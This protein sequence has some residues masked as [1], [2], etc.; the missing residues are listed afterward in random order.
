MHFPENFFW[1]AAISAYQTE[2][3]ITND[4]T[5][6]Y[7][8]GKAVD[9]YNRYDEDFDLAKKLGLNAFRFSIEWARIEPE[10]GRFSDLAIEH[11]KKYISALKQRGP[12]PWLTLWHFTF[13]IWVAKM[14]G[15]ANPDILPYFERF[16]K[17]VAENFGES[18]HFW[19]TINEPTVYANNSYL[20]GRWPPQKIAS[21]AYFKVLKN[22]ARAH[23]LA[24]KIIKSINPDAQVGIAENNTSKR[25]FSR[26]ASTQ[27][28]IGVN[29]YG[30]PQKL[31]PLLQW[32][33]DVYKKP[34]YIT[35]NG[36]DDSLDQKRQKLLA[37][38][39]ENMAKAVQTGIDLRGYF[40]WSLIDNFEWHRGFKP[41]YGL[42]EIDY[43][44]N[45]ARKPRQSYFDYQKIIL[46]PKF[47][48]PI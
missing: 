43:D 16:V 28:F 40:H 29:Y 7:D 9:H 36:I 47:Y 45:L 48:I 11:Y 13:P 26:V 31:I 39:T 24:Y 5:A 22:L 33:N 37:E 21:L 38:M 30:R 10:E 34:I 1:G 35:E 23:G 18:V 19:I 6:S 2:G 8:V 44:N 32:L 20:V 41:R 42:V 27:D 12:E 14:G 15:W 17:L 25:F 4:W 46:N 3:G